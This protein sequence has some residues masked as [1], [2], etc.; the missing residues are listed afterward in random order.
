MVSLAYSQLLISFSAERVL[1]NTIAANDIETIGFY[2]S[3]D[4]ECVTEFYH[5]IY[6]DKREYGKYFASEDVIR[7]MNPAVRNG[8]SL[9]EYFVVESKDQMEKFG[10]EFHCAQA[11][12]D[13]SIFLTDFLIGYYAD[14]LEISEDGVNFEL[15]DRRKHSY[16]DLIGKVT[17]LAGL[18]GY[19]I[20]GVVKTAYKTF[21]DE[22][23]LPRKEMQEPYLHEKLYFQAYKFR[24]AYSFFGVY[25]TETF[26]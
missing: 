15:F 16:E 26:L 17:N 4:P 3:D 10:L 5:D 9:E 22:T 11:L 6:L 20:A 8:R 19:R 1:A 18:D 2:Q 23:F 21:Y 7:K 14:S 13:D 24:E 12:I 25:C